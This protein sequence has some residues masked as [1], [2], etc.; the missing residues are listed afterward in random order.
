M[1]FEEEIEL[2]KKNTREAFKKL[3]ENSIDPNP[4]QIVTNRAER[5]KQQ[6][7]SNRKKDRR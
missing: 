1:L 7:E 4:P 6:R 2:I 5:R 3:L